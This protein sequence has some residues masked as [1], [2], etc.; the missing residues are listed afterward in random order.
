M[1][2]TRQQLFKDAL[3][4]FRSGGGQFS[5][6]CIIQH[7]RGGIISKQSMSS[8]AIT[9]TRTLT[10]DASLEQNDVDSDLSVLAPVRH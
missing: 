6:T 7:S 9:N 2:L 5:N 3:F 10:A 4:F 1:N 8:K